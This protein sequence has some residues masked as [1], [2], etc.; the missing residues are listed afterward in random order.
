MHSKPF[1]LDP[2]PNRFEYP[3]NDPDS[4]ELYAHI[5]ARCYTLSSVLIKFWIG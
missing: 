5:I 1:P 4:V 3:F 2:H